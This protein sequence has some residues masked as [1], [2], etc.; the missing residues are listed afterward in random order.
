MLM[1][2]PLTEIEALYAKTLQGRTV[3][4]FLDA[5]PRDDGATAAANGQLANEL[6]LT[7]ATAAGGVAFA[8]A[9]PSQVSKE[10]PNFGGG[11]G[12][13]T[14]AVTTGMRGEADTDKDGTVVVDELAAFLSR[15]YREAADE[16]GR[17]TTTP[18][19]MITGNG[20]LPLSGRAAVAPPA[21]CESS[22][23]SE[24]CPVS[25]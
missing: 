19:T 1:A 11:H 4:T 18:R 6:W 25:R 15:R 23:P 10:S 16:G 5:G 12:L 7:P 8:A 3:V 24:A 14:F 22:A 17:R 9:G 21:R 20:A 2:I 13:F